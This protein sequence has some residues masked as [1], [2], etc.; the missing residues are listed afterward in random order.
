MNYRKIDNWRE[1]KELSGLKDLPDAPKEIYYL[2]N[3]N[4]KI[5]TNCVA[6]V[7]SRRMTEYGRRVIEK[8]VPQLVFEKKTIISGFMYGVD[9]YAH[10]VCIENNGKTIAV[11][12]WGINIKL[13]GNDRKLAEKIINSGGLLLSEWEDQKGN[14][15]TFPK[16]NRIIAALSHEVI[17]IEAA[18]KSGSL[19]TANLAGKLKRTLWAVPGPI[20]SPTSFGTNSLIAQNQAMMWLGGNPSK[21][22]LSKDPLLNM[23]QSESLTT[24]EIARKLNQSVVQTGAQLSLLTLSGQIVEKGGKYYLNYVD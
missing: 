11:L 22:A 10:Q 14:L 16:R 12:G 21:P 20:T 19:I 18:V 15:W 5:F 23:L 24:N 17:I 7:G 13:E 3:W 4:P 9:Q 8:I 6:I 1:Y 2:G